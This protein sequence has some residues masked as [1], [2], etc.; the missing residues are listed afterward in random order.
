MKKI[1]L[2]MAMFLSLSV[3]LIS[4]APTETKAGGDIDWCLYDPGEGEC[5]FIWV[6]CICYPG[7]VVYG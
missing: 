1:F 4:F 2:S 5:V 6:N 7:V 3:A